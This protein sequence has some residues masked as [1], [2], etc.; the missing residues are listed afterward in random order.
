MA[1]LAC[2][3]E[4]RPLPAPNA[5][6]VTAVLPGP[7]ATVIA[8]SDYGEPVGAAWWHVHEPPLLHDASGEPLPEMVMA[9]VE[10]Q[11]GAVSVRR[12]STRWPLKRPS[13]SAA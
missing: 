3:L 6:A 5:P 8:I 10:G 7:G 12:W 4:D 11:R 13:A 1:C 9:V 2:T